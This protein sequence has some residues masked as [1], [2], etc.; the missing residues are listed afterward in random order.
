MWSVSFVLVKP[1]E[2]DEPDKPNRPN[3]ADKPL[4]RWRSKSVVRTSLGPVAIRYSGNQVHCSRTPSH[5]HFSHPI[6]L[7]TLDLIARISRSEGLMSGSLLCSSN[8]KARLNG[9]C[10]SLYRLERVR[11]ESSFFLLRSSLF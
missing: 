10:S 8:L 5:P 3:E 4:K 6:S 2:P 1:D 7:E 9:L 11:C